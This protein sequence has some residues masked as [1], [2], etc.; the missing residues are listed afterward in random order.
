MKLLFVWKSV[1]LKSKTPQENG[2]EL[3]SATV[4]LDARMPSLHNDVYFLDVLKTR[5]CLK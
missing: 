1:F 3:Y 5:M 2:N 4:K